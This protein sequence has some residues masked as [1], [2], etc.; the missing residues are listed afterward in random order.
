MGTSTDN[1][2]N[3]ANPPPLL[4]LGTKTIFSNFILRNTIFSL[5]SSTHVLAIN[6]TKGSFARTISASSVSVH[7][8]QS[9]RQLQTK[10]LIVTGGAD[11]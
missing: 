8:F 5:T 6:M 9:P 1:L 7:G 10:T 4:V 3:K 11:S 2:Q